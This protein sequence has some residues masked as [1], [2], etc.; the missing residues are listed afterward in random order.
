LA[1]GAGLNQE[2]VPAAGSRGRVRRSITFVNAGPGQVHIL[3][4]KESIYTHGWYL[5]PY[6]G[7]L[8]L[9]IGPD[10][11]VYQGAFWGNATDVGSLTNCIEELYTQ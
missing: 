4:T 6:G 10:G 8:N 2:L 7:A 9:E 3:P 11:Y 5:A 1:A